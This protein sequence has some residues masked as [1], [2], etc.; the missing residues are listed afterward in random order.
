MCRSRLGSKKP[1]GM[2][3]QLLSCRDN[4]VASARY[5][6]KNLNYDRV[7]ASGTLLFDEIEKAHERV[8]DLFLQLLSAARLTLGSGRVLN[9]E[10]FY[11]VATS[12]IGSPLLVGS[13]TNL[14][15]TLVRRVRSRGS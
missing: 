15:E 1:S 14:R 4:R 7:G 11:V 6:V 8:L 2:T 5:E 12:N 3:I 13:K 10:N 9:L